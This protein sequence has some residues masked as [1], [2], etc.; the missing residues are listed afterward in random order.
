MTKDTKYEEM[1]TSSITQEQKQLKQVIRD[2]NQET[3]HI[4]GRYLDKASMAV[5]DR[6][7]LTSQTTEMRKS[8]RTR[9]HSVSMMAEV[10]EK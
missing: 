3:Y 5:T 8:S 9:N 10:Q 6:K 4:L 7:D 1:E 2:F